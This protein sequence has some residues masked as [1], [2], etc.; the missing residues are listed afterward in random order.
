MKR[1]TTADVEP[2]IGECR[3]NIAAIARKLRVSR[4]TVRNRIAESPKLQSALEDAREAFVDEVESALYD[5]ALSGNV[6]AQIFIMKAHPAA[7]TRGWGERT[8]IANPT[9]SEGEPIPFRI[10]DYRAGIAETEE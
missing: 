7:K 2:L 6:A 1:I 5:N 10:I 4:G 9:D 3:G 8:E